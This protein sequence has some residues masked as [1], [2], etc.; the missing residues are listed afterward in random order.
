MPIYTSTLEIS[1]G[2]PTKDESIKPA[3]IYYE[4]GPK[5]YIH[6]FECLDDCNQGIKTTRKYLGLTKLFKYTEAPVNHRFWISKSPWHKE[7]ALIHL[8]RKKDVV[9]SMRISLTDKMNFTNGLERNRDI[10]PVAM[11]EPVILDRIW[12]VDLLDKGRFAIMYSFSKQAKPKKPKIRVKL[13]KYIADDWIVKEDYMKDYKNPDADAEAEPVT[14]TEP[15]AETKP[16]VKAATKEEE[17]TSSEQSVGLLVILIVSGM[18]LVLVTLGG[19]LLIVCR[20]KH[21]HGISPD[22]TTVAMMTPAHKENLDLPTTKVNRN[23]FVV[24]KLFFRWIKKLGGR[25]W[26]SSYCA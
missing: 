14:E 23:K 15:V 18:I 21:P 11:N 26:H 20:K 2:D 25:Q 19:V 22:G 17:T 6:S 9:R 4:E 10:A 13:L 8:I 16:V 5:L 3:Y 7:F 1:W 12:G 24:I